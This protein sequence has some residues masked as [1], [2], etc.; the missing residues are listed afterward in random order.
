MRFLKTS[1][2]DYAPQRIQTLED[3][4]AQTKA[5]IYTSRKAAYHLLTDR[6]QMPPLESFES[7]VSYYGT[8]AYE[9]TH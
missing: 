9:F 6:A 7:A 3:F 5:D 1:C 4:F 2:F 8:L